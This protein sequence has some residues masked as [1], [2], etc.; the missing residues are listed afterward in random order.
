MP[1]ASDAWSGSLV[2]MRQHLANSVFRAVET[3]RPML[4]VSNNGFTCLVS[5][6]GA[7]SDILPAFSRQTA[8]YRLRLS[9]PPPTP[10]FLWGDWL[11]AACL[12]FLIILGGW[13]AGKV[14]H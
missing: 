4:R 13:K 5:P 8:L 3:R 10:Y 9:A 12:L 1:M 14:L 11:P 7:I 6:D 2:A